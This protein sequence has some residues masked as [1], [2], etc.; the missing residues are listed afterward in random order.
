VSVITAALR[1][2]IA[3]GLSGDALVAAIARI[4][5]AHLDDIRSRI[6]S[7]TAVELVGAK[8]VSRRLDV[9]HAEWRALRDET[10]QRDQYRCAYC[11]AEGV[12]T[13]DHVI[14]LAKGGR[15]VPENLVAACK[16]CNSSKRD[17]LVTEWRGRA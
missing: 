9:P 3:A 13:V 7:K 16:P 12:D 17:L 15:S 6:A 1:E 4:E 2:L 11:P 14:P 5:A 10:L 8:A